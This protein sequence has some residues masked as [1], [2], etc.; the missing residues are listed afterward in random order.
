MSAIVGHDCADGHRFSDQ[1]HDQIA[2]ALA[3]PASALA[4]PVT[5][6]EDIGLIEHLDDALR[7]KRTA[8][9]IAE[10]IVR[11]HQLITARYEPELVARRADRVWRRSAT[12]VAEKI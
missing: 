4:H 11:L 3:R 12:T 10:P 6:L 7:G 1:N 2:A 8:F 9:G 5:G